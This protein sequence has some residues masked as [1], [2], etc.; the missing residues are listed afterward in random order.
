MTGQRPRFSKWGYALII[1]IILLVLIGCYAGYYY[2]YSRLIVPLEDAPI[3]PV[4]IVFG[5]GIWPDG[6]LSD[7][8]ADR[9]DTAID[10]YRLGKVSKLLF[11]GDNRTL[12]YNEPQRMR[13]Y[14]LARGIPDEDIVLDYAGRRTYDSC[15]R[16]NYI[17]EVQDAILVTQAYHL[18]RA[19]FTAE[20]MGIRVVGVAADRHAYRYIRNYTLRE[21][22]ATPVAWWQVLVSHP[23]PV[24]GS[25]LPISTT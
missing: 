6:G 17:F 18:P 8:L 16:A 19:L 1:P 24:L 21:L 7:I 20:N 13:E 25:K 10:L 14:A 15:Y 3:K 11:T 2:H 12:D 5:A 9:V 22:A 23:T 4:A